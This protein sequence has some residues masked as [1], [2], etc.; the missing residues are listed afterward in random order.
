MNLGNIQNIIN[1]INLK[2][3]IQVNNLPQ[4]AKKATPIIKASIKN[5]Y[6]STIKRFLSATKSFVEKESKL[7]D[8]HNLKQ[9]T[10]TNDFNES[11]K[12]EKEKF[13]SEE[14][15]LNQ[16]FIKDKKILENNKLQNISNLITHVSNYKKAISEIVDETKKEIDELESSLKNVGL[17]NTCNFKK[18]NP[19]KISMTVKHNPLH[20]IQAMSDT[21]QVIKSEKN[22]AMELIVQLINYRKKRSKLIKIFSILLFGFMLFSCYFLYFK[23]IKVYLN[24]F[25]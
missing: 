3:N 18:L 4:K 17:S 9:K 7:I 10:L 21:N 20:Y 16:L 15:N 2:K 5:N 23:D 1:K 19:Q 12:R 24:Y 14:N 25:M 11:K 22:K 6:K 8:N 13:F